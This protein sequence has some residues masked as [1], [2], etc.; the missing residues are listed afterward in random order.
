MPSFTVYKGSSDGT[1]V[2]ANTT[3]ELGDEEV[4]IQTTHSGVCA[5]DEV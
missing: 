5:S 3:L 4:L 1:I 2:E